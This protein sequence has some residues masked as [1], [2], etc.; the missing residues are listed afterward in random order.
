[1]GKKKAMGAGILII[2]LTLCFRALNAMDRWYIGFPPG[3]FIFS[4]VPVNGVLEPFY[5]AGAEYRF[6]AENSI[7]FGFGASK[8]A[9]VFSDLFLSTPYPGYIWTYS[10]GIGYTRYIW[11]NLGISLSLSPQYIAYYDSGGNFLASGFQLYVSLDIGYRFDFTLFN[12]PL[13]VSV[14]FEAD[15]L[16]YL[17]DGMAPQGFRETD[18]AGSP[19]TF[20]PLPGIEIGYRF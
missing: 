1:M 9:G 10:P 14:F 20:V 5:S 15:W 3:D 17:D 16:A 18:R 4:F 11:E 8:F 13:Y 19:F 12:L 7:T 6:D 2:L